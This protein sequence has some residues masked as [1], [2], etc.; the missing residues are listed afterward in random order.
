M[1]DITTSLPAHELLP[2]GAL[3][4]IYGYQITP[5]RT[6]E[7]RRFNR[8][9][10]SILC[11]RIKSYLGESFDEK[12]FE[13]AHYHD[14]LPDSRHH[15]F[16]KQMSRSILPSDISREEPYLQ[17]ILKCAE[18]LFKKRARIYND[19]IEYRV[20]RPGQPDNNELH[21][22]HWFPYFKNL[23]NV[24][25]PLAG[26]Y[27]DSAMPIVPRSHLWSDADVV[28]EI[29]YEGGKY[30]K[31]STGIA[32]SVS[33]IKS[34][35]REIVRH[36]PDTVEGS[37]MLFSPLLIHGGGDNSSPHTRFSFEFRLELLE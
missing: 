30:I 34:C 27:C 26:S 25:V 29:Q 4:H 13:L 10:T 16:I 35:S 11:A 15:D 9:F 28:P 19:K 33:P 2:E 36:R 18:T 17:Y 31:P 23:V 14:I 37:S 7:Y 8:A 20:V 24:Y 32:Y 22:D 6:K 1:L 21:R 3:F 5:P 12:S